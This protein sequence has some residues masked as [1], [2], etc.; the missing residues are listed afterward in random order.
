MITV[1]NGIA[2]IDAIKA[3]KKKG[4]TVIVTD[5]HQA[6]VDE[7]GTAFFRKRILL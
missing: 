5:H 6:P 4:L 3:A 1:D 7:K 2:A